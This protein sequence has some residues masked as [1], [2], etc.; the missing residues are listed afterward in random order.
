[1]EEIRF[2]DDGD[3]S[4]INDNSNNLTRLGHCWQY[5]KATTT[6]ILGD[7]KSKSVK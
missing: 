2:V 1:M 3:C 7:I 4:E 6:E 5:R